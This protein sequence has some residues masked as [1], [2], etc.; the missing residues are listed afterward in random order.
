VDL[1]KELAN[2]INDFESGGDND[3]L[4]GKEAKDKIKVEE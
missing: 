2:V 1:D 3:D 4:E